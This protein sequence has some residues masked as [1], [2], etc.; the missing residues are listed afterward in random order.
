VSADWEKVAEEK[1]ETMM[2]RARMLA[3]MLEKTEQALGLDQFTRFDDDSW[4]DV[5]VRVQE[6]WETAALAFHELGHA[7]DDLAMA[8]ED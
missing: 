1:F 6:Q 5:R 3:A 8:R 4:P 7:Y 2:M